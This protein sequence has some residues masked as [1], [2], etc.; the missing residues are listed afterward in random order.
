MLSK[1]HFAA[2]VLLW[3]TVEAQSSTS[4]EN[5]TEIT[6]VTNSQ[7]S[8]ITDIILLR[9]QYSYHSHLLTKS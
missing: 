3:N 1:T 2:L 8:T 9:G 4:G 6:S 5:V 7:D